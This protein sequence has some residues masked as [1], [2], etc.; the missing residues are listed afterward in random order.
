MTNYEWFPDRQ[1][2]IKQLELK[3]VEINPKHRYLFIKGKNKKKNNGKS[4][5]QNLSL[6]KRCQQEI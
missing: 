4:K 6:S 5:L 2:V 1:E 3:S